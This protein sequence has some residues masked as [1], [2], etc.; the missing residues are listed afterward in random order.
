[1]NEINHV[2]D[3][4]ASSNQTH[5]EHRWSGEIQTRNFRL[6]A[7]S[8]TDTD[9]TLVDRRTLGTVEFDYVRVGVELGRGDTAQFYVGEYD[10]DKNIPIIGMTRVGDYYQHDLDNE[11]L[12]TLEYIE[13]YH[14]FPKPDLV[15]D[16]QETNDI[17]DRME[18]ESNE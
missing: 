17:V 9:Y 6:R 2:H 3:K 8:G 18:V 13:E 14:E 15:V 1:M 4:T 11:I 16:R 12:H 10:E 5:S 7:T